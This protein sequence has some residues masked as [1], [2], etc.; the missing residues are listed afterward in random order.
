MDKDVVNKIAVL[1]DAEN[2]SYNTIDDI[3]RK[4]KGNGNI[5]INRIYGGID[6]PK[7]WKNI[8]NKY[9][10]TLRTQFNNVSGK[11]TSDSSLIIDAMDILYTKEIDTFYIISSDSDFTG[12]ITRIKEDNKLVVGIGEKKIADSLINACNRFIFIENLMTKSVNVLVKIGG[13]KM[14]LAIINDEYVRSIE[15]YRGEVTPKSSRSELEE[16]YYDSEFWS[17][18]FS[19]QALFGI[20]NTKEEAIEKIRYYFNKLDTEGKVDEVFTFYSCDNFT[21]L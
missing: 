8:C 10:I 19:I 14:I 15:V 13:K 1:I 9:S 11:N 18:N 7:P 4:I 12:L 21:K 6:M 20:Y 2:I 17:D 3:F 16:I 5:L